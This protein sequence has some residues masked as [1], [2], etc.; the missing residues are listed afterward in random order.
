MLGPLPTLH[1]FLLVAAALVVCV[2]LGLWIG[3]VPELALDLRVGLVAGTVAGFAA[4][5]ALV[6]DSHRRQG[7]PARL[8]RRH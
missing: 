2:G 6:H 1:R 3:T 7:R 5:F 4:A 8:R